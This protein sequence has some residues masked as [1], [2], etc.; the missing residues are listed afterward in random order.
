MIGLESRPCRRA[1][2][3]AQQAADTVILLS[4]ED[5]QYYTLNGVGGRVWELC[6]GSLRV[7]D[8]VSMIGQEYEATA[9]T[10]EAD[11]LELLQELVNA[12]LVMN[13]SA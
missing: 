9:E 5:G 1:Q 11:I 6:N 13:G 8:V 7:V 4:L 2:V 3:I 10:I 12:K